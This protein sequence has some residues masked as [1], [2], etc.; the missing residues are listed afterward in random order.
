MNNT[1][2]ALT[3]AVVI[4]KSEGET[5][6]EIKPSRKDA[7]K[8]AATGMV[9]GRFFGPVGMATGAL[10]GGTLGYVFGSDND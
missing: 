3:A 10:V 5:R 4:N 9:I 7:I 1:V 2:S 6:Y 8:G